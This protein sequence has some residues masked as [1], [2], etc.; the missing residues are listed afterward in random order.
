MELLPTVLTLTIV[1]PI[2]GGSLMRATLKKIIKW[3]EHLPG[4]IQDFLSNHFK[5]VYYK[6]LLKQHPHDDYGHHPLATADLTLHESYR[7]LDGSENNPNYDGIGGQFLRAT[8]DVS[9]YVDGIEV[10]IADTRPSAREISNA[11]FSQTGVTPNTQ[12]VSDFFWLWGQFID[13][14]IDL[15]AESVTPEYFNIVVPE[16]DAYFPPGSPIFLTR[17]GYDPATG[18]DTGLQREQVN[19]ITPFIDA[20]QIYGVDEVRNELMRG[21]GGKLVMGDGDL[22]PYNTYGMPNAGGSFDTLFLA[23]DVRANENVALTSMHTLFVR[24]HN[25]LVDE[26]VKLHPEFTDEQLYQEAKL[27]V[28]AEIQSIT[29]N[30]FLPLLLGENAVPEYQG[31]NPDVDPE[32]ANLFATAAYRLGHSMLSSQLSRVDENGDEYAGG[33]LALAQ[34]F[35]APYLLNEADSLESLMRGMATTEAQALD[36]QI[37]DDVRNFLFGAP[38]AGGFD[39][40]SLNIQRGRDHGLP[41]YNSAREAYGLD[42][43]SDFS[44]ITQNQALANLLSDLYS[45]DV[46]NIDVYVGG[47]AE[48]PYSDSMLGELFHHVVLDQ[49]LRIRD[50]DSL[51]YESRLSESELDWINDV[52]LSDIIKWNS[53][54]DYLQENIFIAMDRF[55]GDNAKNILHGD[56]GPDL[57]LGFAGADKLYGHDGN[58][59]LYG[60]DGADMLF[61]GDGDDRLVGELGHD[62][63][64]GGAGDDTY[65]VTSGLDEVTDWHAGDK[66]D[67]SHFNIEYEDLNIIQKS[68]DTLVLVNGEPSVGVKL[69]DVDADNLSTDDFIF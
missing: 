25:R 60:G 17:S 16:D 2:V 38:G 43:V 19:D 46:N 42:P 3:G 26:L 44:E 4:E 66:I 23:G 14:D 6:F 24:E 45:G 1:Q 29:F 27:L 59:E 58:D 48:D 47:L 54:V 33:H 61:G 37:V 10:P 22:L 30:D 40:A 9:Y 7:A 32:I 13:H 20:S 39:L 56:D 36:A 51:W 64:T 5:D 55:G 63:L 34:A 69:L 52:H 53:D 50:G 65:V 12:G 21:E 57:I 8:P 18:G 67:V 41:D 31:Y 68:H 28:E 49:F 15:T 11:V 35:F 62:I